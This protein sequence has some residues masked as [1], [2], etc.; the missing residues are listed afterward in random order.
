MPATQRYLGFRG[1]RVGIFV[2]ST[3]I[4]LAFLI[5]NAS[6]DF[7]PF[8]RKLR[9]RARFISADGLRP[10]AEVQLAGIVIGRVEDV[11][12]LPP[13]DTQPAKIEAILSV[14]AEIDGRPINER[15]RTDSTAQLIATSVLANDKIINITPGT[16]K[17][18]PVSE[19]H[20]L[21]SSAAISINQLTQTGND[22]LNQI[23]KLSIPINEILD[24]ANRGEGSLGRFINDE[25]LYENLNA[26]INETRITMIKLQRTLDEINAGKG[27]AGKFLTDPGLYNSLNKTAS[28][29]E[30]ISM[31]L[32]Q[33][34]GTAGKLLNDE[35]LYNNL[36]ETINEIRSLARRLDKTVEGFNQILIDVNQGKGT[37][38]K[39]FKDETLY[40]DLRSSISRIDL[41]LADV[42]NGKGTIGKLFTD[43][44]LYENLNQTAAN[45]NQFSSE[46]TKLLNDFRQ[47]PK[48][49]LT[50]KLKIF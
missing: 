11:R 30:A 4:A 13:D 16:A 43:E 29:L 41:L 42:R 37:I 7:N 10:G 1:L 35:K 6:G 28:Q 5:I 15:I 9:L 12:F 23:N 33:G 38:G 36:N 19:D 8:E 2:A 17:G 49:F 27:S 39:L 45:I 47:N 21:E 44:T 25:S 3:L 31:D 40:R 34:R 24:K 14:S 20:I 50:I 26:T 46:G 32:R 48:K 18:E 22:L